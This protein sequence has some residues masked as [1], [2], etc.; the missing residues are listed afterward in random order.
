MF[1]LSIRVHPTVLYDIHVA[2]PQSMVVAVEGRA[3]A[4]V[5]PPSSFSSGAHRIVAPRTAVDGVEDAKHFLGE[6][7]QN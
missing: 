7:H 4:A 6:E 2:A 5:V 3:T 1:D